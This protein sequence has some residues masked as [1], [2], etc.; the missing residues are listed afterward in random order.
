MPID[1]AAPADDPDTPARPDAPAPPDAPRTPDAFPP[2]PAPA[3]RDAIH[4]A[5]RAKADRS[6]P[7]H[8]AETRDGTPADEAGTAWAEAVPSLRA[9]W[10]DHQERYPERARATPVTH[11]DNSWSSGAARQLTPDQN[12]TVAQACDRIR[13]IGERDIVPGILAVEAADPARQLAGFDRRF[14]GEDR[15][16]EKVA[17]R[18]RTTGRAPDQALAEVADVVRFTYQYSESTYA[19]GVQ[20]DVKRLE[21]RGFNKVELRNT[22]DNDQYKGI[23][24]RWREPKSGTLFEVQFHTQASLEAKELT[25]KAYER[26]RSTALD[27]ERAELKQFQRRVNSM[28]PIPPGAAEIEDYPPGDT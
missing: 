28:I 22:W 9:A 7:A 23:N 11:P 17:D 1:H 16:K 5:Y 3:D 14:K 2:R 26:I 18:I 25:H 24:T 6:Y 15:L 19:A 10:A 12:A 8:R 20:D 21:D 4:R 27:A 13:E